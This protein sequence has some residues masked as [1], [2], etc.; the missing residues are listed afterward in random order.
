TIVDNEAPPTVQFSA[1]AFSVAENAG[2]AVMTVTLSAPSA[3]TATV[4]LATSNSTASSADDYAAVP[5]GLTFAPG[6]TRV[7]F[8]V[9]ITDDVFEEPNESVTLALSVPN[10]ATLG[11]PH[12]AT[13]TILDNDRILRLYLPLMARAFAGGPNLVPVSFKVSPAAPIVSQPT[14]FTLAIQNQGTTPITKE[15]WVDLYI[16]PVR[17]PSAANET[18]DQ[19]CPAPPTPCYGGAWLITRTL[20]PGQLITLTS[21]MLL[22]EYTRWPGWFVTSGSHSV[23]VYVDSYSPNSS[24][25]A[26]LETSESDNRANLIVQVAPS[27]LQLQAEPPPQL[28][29]PLRSDRP[30]P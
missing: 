17:P 12:S 9:P 28:G 30:P 3:F 13:L 20:A 27:L 14:T 6:A 16:D 25:G 5:S 23:Y 22:P 10:N 1:A 4:N 29:T 19:L 24:S 18:W 8:T 2:P 15:F 21:A 26:I 11:T 7:S